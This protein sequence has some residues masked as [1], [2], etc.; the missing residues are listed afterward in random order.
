MSIGWNAGAI[1]IA[2]LLAVVAAYSPPSMA[3]AA[4]VLEYLGYSFGVS[5]PPTEVSVNGEYIL[6]DIGDRN[7]FNIHI[8]LDAPASISF[9]GEVGNGENILINGITAN[10]AC[11][12]Y[13]LTATRDGKTASYDVAVATSDVDFPLCLPN[14]TLK[15]TGIVVDPVRSIDNRPPNENGA[16]PVRFTIPDSSMNIVPLIYPGADLGLTVYLPGGVTGS[17]GGVT[18]NSPG[19]FVEV[20]TVPGCNQYNLVL[21]NERGQTRTVPIL[22]NGV[23][24]QL[25]DCS[26]G[27]GITGTIISPPTT[28]T[29]SSSSSSSSSSRS[30]S[31]SGSFAPSISLDNPPYVVSIERTGNA[32]TL[33]GLLEWDVTFSESV[34]VGGMARINQTS[35]AN[36]TIP[37][38]GTIQDTILVGMAGNVTNGTVSV[39][40]THPIRSGLVIELVAP[41]CTRY[42]VHNQTHA[43]AYELREPHNLEGVAGTE[44]AGPW[45]LVISDMAKWLD[46]TLNSW[47]MVLDTDIRVEGSGTKYTFTQYA[48]TDDAHFLDLDP[49]DIRDRA[50]NPLSDADPDIN[51]SY[52]V[53][54]AEQRTC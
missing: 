4:P 28:S 16:Y 15:I 5:D 26:V 39:N 20:W 41:D 27:G 30:T 29:S 49:Y 52:L 40:L 34:R 1:G 33:G 44:A 2:A 54:G 6:F 7:T 38:L 36:L 24:F 19:M 14:N 43:F 13:K 31:F 50:G 37:D 3:D 12:Q 53:I 23:A 47:N 18:G 51:E 9:D 48:G 11:N 17:L 22:L 42:L 32:T 10:Q 46:G 35:M 25:N 45:T 8:G 21:T